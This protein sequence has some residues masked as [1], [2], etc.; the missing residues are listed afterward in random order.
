MELTFNQCCYLITLLSRFPQVAGE[1]NDE[2]KFEMLKELSEYI[3][4]I[5]DGE[6]TNRM[7]LNQAVRIDDLINALNI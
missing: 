4:C 1:I 6:T 2:E 5:E 7:K 3:S